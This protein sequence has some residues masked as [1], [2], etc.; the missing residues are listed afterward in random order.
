MRLLKIDLQFQNRGKEGSSFRV[1]G[2]ELYLKEG[3]ERNGTGL[4]ENSPRK[5]IP[6]NNGEVATAMVEVSEEKNKEIESEKTSLL[7]FLVFLIVSCITAVL[8]I[9]TVIFTFSKT[10]SEHVWIFIVVII[11]IIVLSVICFTFFI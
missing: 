5:Y 11:A 1:S 10:P 9:Y 7:I 8:I 6:F 4:L 3:E 2:G